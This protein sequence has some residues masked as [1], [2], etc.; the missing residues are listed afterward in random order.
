MPLSNPICD[1]YLNRFSYYKVLLYGY[2]QGSV[3][4]HLSASLGDQIYY[5]E[6]AIKYDINII[7]T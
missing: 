7:Y 4:L 1:N 2:C 6:S 5:T 3:I